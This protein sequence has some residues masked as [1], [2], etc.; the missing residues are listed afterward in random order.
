MDVFYSETVWQHALHVDRMVGILTLVVDCNVFAGMSEDFI[1]FLPIT[2]L[3]YLFI[4]SAGSSYIPVYLIS[5]HLL[6]S[7]CSD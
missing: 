1:F 2:V 7:A 5:S 6:D 4:K 3:E